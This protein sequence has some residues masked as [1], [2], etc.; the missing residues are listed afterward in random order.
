MTRRDPLDALWENPRA[1]AQ[2]APGEPQPAPAPPKRAVS[3]ETRRRMSEAAKARHKR[4]RR[5]PP[6][7]RVTPLRPI[8]LPVKV[9]E[10]TVIVGAGWR[11]VVAAG[12]VT[13]ELR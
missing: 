13:V 9:I 1:Q 12:A 6:A 11:V 5:A 4:V 3:E 7:G 10:R 8:S 2:A